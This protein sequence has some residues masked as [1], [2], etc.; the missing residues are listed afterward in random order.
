[1]AVPGAITSPTSVGTNRLIRDGAAPLLE[2]E[3][4]LEHYPEVAAA[5]PQLALPVEPPEPALPDSLSAGERQVAMLLDR[6]PRHLD[7]L[8]SLAGMAPGEVLGLLCGLELAGVVE[9]VPGWRFRRAP[10]GH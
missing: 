3:D 8:A 9:Q 7:D 1:M 10:A 5:S 2:V 4:L 6:E